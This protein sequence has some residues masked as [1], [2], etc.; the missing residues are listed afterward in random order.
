ML[1]LTQ[2]QLDHFQ[3]N[4]RTLKLHATKLK[5]DRFKTY[6]TKFME[7]FQINFQVSQLQL[8][9]FDKTTNTDLICTDFKIYEDVLHH[10]VK[11]A[12]KFSKTGQKITIEVEYK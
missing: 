3:F 1:L 12:I 6:V 11:N 5:Q 7:P 2:S 8:E 9:I 10:I 4:A